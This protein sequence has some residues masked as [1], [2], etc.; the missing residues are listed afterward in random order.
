MNDKGD[1]GFI[2]TREHRRFGEFCDACERDHYIG[3]CY[4][5]PGVGKTLSARRYTRWDKIQAYSMSRASV[6]P[7]E[8]CKSKAVFYTTPVINSP[9]K[10]DSDIGKCRDLLRNIAMVPVRRRA[11]ARLMR[12]LDRM[13]ELRNPKRNPDNYRGAAA[14]KAE[15]DFLEQRNR[16]TRLKVPDPTALLVVDEAD[17]LKMASL[18]QIRD[19]FDR[20]GIGLVLIGMPGIEKRLAR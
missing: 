20:G 3:L 13:D 2:E 14:V 7:K 19:I 5:P 11:Q 16:I 4:G 1:I 8:I 12:L 15:D 6:P 9:G 10:L 17:R 18:E